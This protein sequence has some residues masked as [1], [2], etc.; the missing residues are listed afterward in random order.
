MAPRNGIEE[1]NDDEVV[2]VTL[3]R[4]DYIVMRDMIEKQKSLTWIGKYVRNVIFV[5]AG[6]ILG[7]LAFGEQFLKI[8]KSLLGS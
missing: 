5:F 3:S 1:H 8:L 7:V 4:R 2:S 6:G